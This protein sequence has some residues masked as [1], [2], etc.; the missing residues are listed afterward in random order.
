MDR[1]CRCNVRLDKA[2]QSILLHYADELF[3]LRNWGVVQIFNRVILAPIGSSA[4]QGR[5]GSVPVLITND[6]CCCRDWAN[7]SICLK[8]VMAAQGGSQL[9][10]CVPDT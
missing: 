7:N 2:G 1:A 3:R 6:G 5:K 10:T 9:E 8:G 4:Y